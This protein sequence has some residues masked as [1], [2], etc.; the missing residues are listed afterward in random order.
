MNA[1]H[2]RLGLLSLTIVLALGG[3]VT[4]DDVASGKAPHAKAQ[5]H[6]LASAFEAEERYRTRLA[7]LQ[8]L[9]ELAIDSSDKVRVEQ[10]SE[11]RRM[12]LELGHDQRRAHHAQLVDEWRT[13]YEQQL[14]IASSAVIRT[15]PPPSAQ[16]R[17]ARTTSDAETSVFERRRQAARTRIAD[18]RSAALQR[19]VEAREA[20][21]ARAEIAHQR[22]ERRSVLDE[23]VKPAIEV[24]TSS[25]GA[26]TGA[27]EAK[28][29]K[30]DA[31]RPLLITHQEAYDKAAAAIRLDNATRVFWK[32][33]DTIT[34]E[35]KARAAHME[36]RAS[37]TEARSGGAK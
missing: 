7:R 28:P 11:L 4:A 6:M 17:A 1:S 25:T 32:M 12:A 37:A 20:M 3:P 29:A 35:F 10:V 14:E 34:G 22:V 36:R 33:R 24:K 13:R 18:R 19:Q 31:P 5:E 2:T 9:L 27:A 8:R 21:L 23:S 16:R 26:A 15:A 30:A